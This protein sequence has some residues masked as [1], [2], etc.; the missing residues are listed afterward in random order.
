MSNFLISIMFGAGVSAFVYNRF[1]RRVG[2]GNTQ[3]QVVLCVVVFLLVTIIFF[4]VVS[5]IPQ[6]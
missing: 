2:Y 4:T 5:T 6:K 3:N 1:S